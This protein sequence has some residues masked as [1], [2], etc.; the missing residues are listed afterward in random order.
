MSKEEEEDMFDDLGEELQ[1]PSNVDTSVKN[2]ITPDGPDIT[3]PE[4]NDHVMS[5]FTEGELIDGKPLVDGLRRVSQLLLGRIVSAGPTQVFPPATAEHH[6]RATVVFEV[7]F[8]NNMRFAD[9]ADVW[10][11]NTDDTFCAFAT[12]TASTRA[13]ARALRKALR[14]RTCSA[15]EMTTKDTAGIVKNLSKAAETTGITTGD[16][17]EKARMTSPQA[18]FISVRCK[19]MNINAQKLFKI[20]LGVENAGRI[21]KQ[22]ASTA[23][24]TLNGYLQE[25]DTIPGEILGF[26]NGWES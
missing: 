22:T 14:L 7:V 8:E 15:E 3:D 21:D 10:E 6:G 23:I 2:I 4:W 20:V 16:Y 17:N 25:L 1:T 12:A 11:G 13:E 24:D 26:E 5:F 19:E 9:V 18:N